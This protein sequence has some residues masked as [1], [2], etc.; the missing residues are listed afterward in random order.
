M[1]KFVVPRR[2][3]AHRVAG[4]SFLLDQL[5]SVLFRIFSNEEWF[6]LAALNSVKLTTTALAAIALYRAL[7]TQC[8]A[9]SLPL[10]EDQR[11]ALRNIVRN[12]F[13]RNRHVHSSRLLKLAF[14]TGYELLDTLDRASL[15]ATEH[16]DA[17][18]QEAATLLTSLLISAPPHLT[19]PPRRKPGLK[20]LDP[21]PEA[22]PPPEQT[23]LALRPRPLSELG[24]TGIRQVPHLFSANLF[25][26][27]RIGKPQPR[28]LSRVLTDKVKQRQRRLNVREKSEDEWAELGKL[29]DEWDRIVSE[30]C[31]VKDLDT[32][33]V[34]T[35]DTADGVANGRGGNGVFHGVSWASE[36]LRFVRMINTQLTTQKADTERTVKRMQEIVDQE[37]ELAYKEREARNAVRRQKNLEERRE[38]DV[39]EI[40]GTKDTKKDRPI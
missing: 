32:Y 24:G 39:D 8:A 2:S 38:N 1:P 40:L 14:T 22:C 11:A 21:S 18:A 33:D 13:R 20:R 23:V 36:P 19:G 35:E 6:P 37:A 17:S 16:A 9:P 7:L 31:G 4:M 10:A 34:Q 28:S 12:K 15:S 5:P 27:L 30:V 29:E 3:G 26:V 25:P